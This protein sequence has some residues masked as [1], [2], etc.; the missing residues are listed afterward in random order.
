MSLM[1]ERQPEPESKGRSVLQTISRF[2][3]VGVVIAILYLA[4]TFYSRHLSDEQAAQDLA[5]KKQAQRQ[6]EA[7]LIFGS[8]EVKIVSYSVDK[9]SMALGESA[10]LCYGVVNATKVVIEPHLE[11]SKPSSYHCLTVSPKAT[12]TYTITASNDKGE[13]KSLSVTVKVH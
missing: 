11:D 13:S 5:A 9:A 7:D 12:T 6:H 4:W 2:A 8:G 1:N 3:T 10:D